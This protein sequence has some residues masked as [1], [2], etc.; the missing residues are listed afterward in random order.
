MAD[1]QRALTA[2]LVDWVVKGTPPPASRYP[3]LAERMLVPA[4]RAA[5]GFPAIPGV[6]FSDDLVNVVLDYDFGSSFLYNDL[7]GVI[8]NQPPRITQ[9]LPTLVPRV[10]ADGNETSGI[11]SVLH[12]APL[13]T[14]LGWNVQKSG[15][16]KG[17]IC[18]FQGG[19]VPFAATRAERQASG[20]PRPS[21][22]E[23]YGTQDGYVC[24]VQAR[25]RCAGS[26]SV[27]APRQTPIVSWPRRQRALSCHANADA[28]PAA[29]QTAAALCAALSSQPWMLTLL[30]LATHRPS[31]RADPL[32]HHIGARRADARARRRGARRRVRRRPGRVRDGRH[33]QRRADGRASGVRGPLLRRDARRRALRS[34]DPPRDWRSSATIRSRSWSA[35]PPSRRLRTSTAPARA[36]SW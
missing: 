29:R 22:E 36:R 2:A 14:Y 10:N 11:A 35:R 16:F 5:I 19:Y 25:R 4:T 9:V 18:G 24:T 27:S 23:R 20:D 7:S 15:F 12:Q 34:A 21:L 8:A 13:G 1:T 17:Q 31:A 26:R 6:T 33:A 32:P 30:G 28:T 3:T